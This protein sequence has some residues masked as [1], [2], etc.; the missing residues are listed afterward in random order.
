MKWVL[1]ILSFNALALEV[2][3]PAFESQLVLKIIRVSPDEF[4]T[5]AL[6]NHNYREMTLTCA[7]NIAYDHNKKPILEYRNYYN[8][9]AG[10]FTFDDDRACQDMA[11]FIE[12]VSAA[13]NEERP[14]IIT[15]NKKTLKVEKIVYPRIDEFA[16]DGD[17][18]DLLPKKL[19]P[20]VKTPPVKVQHN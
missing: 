10:R 2:V 14:F 8:E 19:I 20:P 12:T 1:L 13:V 16:D 6:T 15:L 11:R 5:Y 4:G 18:A 9:I 7:D 3:R 17:I